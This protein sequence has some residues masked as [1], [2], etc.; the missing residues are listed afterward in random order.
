MLS[1]RPGDEVF[2]P[3]AGSGS[4]G[5]AATLCGRNWIGCE[6]DNAMYEKANN[7]LNNIDYELA[8][9]YINSRV[10]NA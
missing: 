10:H 8:K 4:S 3:F 6:L 2:D 1:S 7:W 9:E 5:V